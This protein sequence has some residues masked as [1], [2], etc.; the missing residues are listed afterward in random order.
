MIYVG[1]LNLAHGD[2]VVGKE[3]TVVDA[4]SADFGE[5]LVSEEC[6]FFSGRLK[7]LCLLREHEFV[8]FVLVLEEL[9]RSTE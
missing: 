6:E 5:A 8:G 7:D 1:A 4:D 9:F 2:E 3:L